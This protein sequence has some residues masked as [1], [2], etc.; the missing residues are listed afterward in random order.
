MAV[1]R[2][3][4][5]PDRRLCQKATP[6]SEITQNVRVIWEDMIETMEGVPGVGLAAPQIGEMLRLV[7]VD[8]SESRGKAILMANPEILQISKELY[9]VHEASPNVP[10]ISARMQRPKVVSV[11]YLNS[12]GDL[13]N[14][15]FEDLWST[16]VQHQID[17]LN[18]K[19]FF[20]N[21]SKLRR[22]MLLRR[23][24]KKK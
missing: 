1:R 18:G 13:E 24:R 6:V 12:D 21:L 11:Q 16:S 17:H 8:A 4:P 9:E 19:M 10:G 5:W 20:H 15:D 23:A 22:D 3:I 14:R 2:F 7:V